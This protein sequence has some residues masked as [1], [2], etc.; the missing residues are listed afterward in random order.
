MIENRIQIN[1]LRIKLDMIVR[2]RALE[3]K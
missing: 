1:R 3:E 2:D